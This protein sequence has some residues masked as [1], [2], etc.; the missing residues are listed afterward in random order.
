M[1]GPASP[2][3]PGR[4]SLPNGHDQAQSGQVQ[5]RSLGDGDRRAVARFLEQQWGSAVQVAHGT[6][7]RPAE[8][9]GLIAQTPSEPMAG[10]V[11]YEVRGAVLEIV[12]LNAVPRRAGIGTALL[13]EA[14][15]EA[16]RRGC[17]EVRL[18]T[19]NDNVGA[20]R[21]YQRRGFR[22]VELRPGAVTRARRAKPE[23]PMTG[24]YGIPLRDEL[25]LIRSVHLYARMSGREPPGGRRRARRAWAA[26]LLLSSDCVLS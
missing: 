8:L 14:V 5:I 15:A 9:P 6:V 22:L 3:G 16:I 13:E 7:F 17:R 4:R 11:T 12:T 20:L 2:T 25:D 18:T 24:E 19:T 23:I 1:T 26:H 21:F 10:L